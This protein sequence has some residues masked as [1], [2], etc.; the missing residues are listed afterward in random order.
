MKGT[1][2]D[3]HH[4]DEYNYFDTNIDNDETLFTLNEQRKTIEEAKNFTKYMCSPE[5]FDLLDMDAIHPLEGDAMDSNLRI[6]T[7]RIITDYMDNMKNKA[8]GIRLYKN[9]EVSSLYDSIISKRKEK[10]FT[11][12]QDKKKNDDSK[13]EFQKQFIEFHKKQ[14]S[15]KENLIKFLLP[16]EPITEQDRKR[17]I[18]TIRYDNSPLSLK[19]LIENYVYVTYLCNKDQP[20]KRYKFNLLDMASKT[21]QFGVQH[22]KNKF[23]KNDIRY[24]EGSHLVFE[25]SVFVETGCTNPV[26][27]AKL[28]EHT[29][30]ILKYV[31]GYHNID[32]KERNC[33]NVVATGIFNSGLCLELLKE[34]FPYVTYE[35][36]NFAGAIIR[37]NDIDN[38][39]TSI[40]NNNNSN[41]NNSSGGRTS[42]SKLDDPNEFINYEK[43]D[44][45]RND[46]EAYNKLYNKNNHHYTKFTYSDVNESDIIN[47]NLSMNNNNNDTTS[48]IGYEVNYDEFDLFHPVRKN[49]EKNVTALVFP[50]GQVICVGNDSRDG[51]IE[52]Y[53]KLFTILEQCRNTKENIKL[54]KQII[55]TRRYNY[56]K[57][58]N[59][60]NS[61]KNKQPS[62]SY[63]KEII[64]DVIIINKKT[65]I[66][67]EEE[68]EEHDDIICCIHCDYNE[69]ETM[70]RDVRS[71][72]CSD[73]A[74]MCSDCDKCVC[75]KCFERYY[76]HNKK[77]KNYKNSACYDNFICENCMVSSTTKKRKRINEDE[78]EEGGNKRK[79]I[80]EYDEDR[81][82]CVHC[83]YNEK[84]SHFISYDNTYDNSISEY[85][86]LCLNCGECV[87]KDCFNTYYEDDIRYKRF[88]ESAYKERFYCN[89]CL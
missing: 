85:A 66:E 23:S 70:F 6:H 1:S 38:H 31:C 24:N 29:M 79:K 50:L 41:S 53:T 11:V 82:K 62:P 87:C 80:K 81:P 39:N 61:K 55:Q 72:H 63:H 71:N 83:E 25:S 75:F 16:K 86:L 52:S 56:S 4:K 65:T 37:I 2:V 21:L 5:L 58:K 67:E 74:T 7:T 84:L 17:E 44:G 27:A 3:N 33:H 64:P 35:K 47:Q 57:K 36:K 54:E 28:L 68:S 22:S 30:N 13:E 45:Y 10:G 69:K 78:K 43:N 89:K 8:L 49:K 19:I 42:S 26:L 48:S 76:L 40:N 14:M 77:Y 51:V 59:N 34:R 18:I 20:N 88:N 12:P 60:R 15:I 9:S 46:E 73:G 32:I